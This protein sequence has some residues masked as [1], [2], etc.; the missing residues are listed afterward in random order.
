MFEEDEEADGCFSSFDSAEI[1]VAA[2]KY[3]SKRC[4]HVDTIK[5]KTNTNPSMKVLLIYTHK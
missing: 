2:R 4:S 5:C 1:K 3:I